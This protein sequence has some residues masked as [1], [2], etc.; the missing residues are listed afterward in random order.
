MTF[1]KLFHLTFTYTSSLIIKEK[2]EK[3]R[4]SIFQNYSELPSH[5]EN[6]N[7]NNEKEK[8]GDIKESKK[9]RNHVSLL[10]ERNEEKE[11]K[12]ERK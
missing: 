9:K 12:R 4:E 11:E 7:N 8:K 1:L 3:R 5:F 10:T 6:N 2:K